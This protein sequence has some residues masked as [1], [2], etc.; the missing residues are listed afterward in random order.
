MMNVKKIEDSDGVFVP[1]WDEITMLINLKKHRLGE[2]Y[3]FKT[4]EDIIREFDGIAQR[5]AN[6]R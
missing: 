4:E 3:K 6:N 5:R 1:E 2:D